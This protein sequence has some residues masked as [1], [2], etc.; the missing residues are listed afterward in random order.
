MTE[1]RR[2]KISSRQI[3]GI[4]LWQP[5]LD[6]DPRVGEGVY[7]PHTGWAV[8][9]GPQP[10]SDNARL[11]SLHESY[12]GTLNDSTSY[13]AMLH[14]ASRFFKADPSNENMSAFFNA[15]SKESTETHELYATYASLYVVS[16]GQPITSLLLPYNDYQEFFQ[17]AIN[18]SSTL[19]NSLMR[20][21]FIQSACRCCMQTTCLENLVKKSPA[22]WRFADIEPTDLPDKRLKT[23]RNST[24]GNDIGTVLRQWAMTQDDRVQWLVNIEEGD[25]RAYERVVAADFDDVLDQVGFFFYDVVARRLERAGARV[26]SFNGHQEAVR[27]FLR[28]M[29]TYLPNDRS[30]AP[31]RAASQGNATE[32]ALIEQFAEERL[33]ISTQ[34]YDARLYDIDYVDDATLRS[35]LTGPVCHGSLVVRPVG[36]LLQLYRFP[37]EDRTALAGGFEVDA[38]LVTLRRRVF[39][40]GI[41]KPLIEHFIVQSPES[42]SRLN[43]LTAHGV[44]FVGS[45][46]LRSAADRSWQETWLGPL[47]QFV[48]LS[49]LVD[50]NPF[51]QLRA[52]GRQRE[53]DVLYGRIDIRNAEAT[54]I[55]Y[56]LYPLSGDDLVYIIPCSGI[57]ANAITHTITSLQDK[58]RFRADNSVFEDIRHRLEYTLSHLLREE[59]WFDFKLP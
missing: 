41:G 18:I 1:E 44:F 57:V 9:L 39:R 16:K 19:P 52:W 22:T 48:N 14:V 32:A 10:H 21:L 49:V 12:H 27:D 29:K 33:V 51:Y 59:P 50:S 25:T 58:S 8:R 11:V 28:A 55:V 7:G 42:L 23:L 56:G 46:S 47:A 37:N 54:H 35:L 30:L 36:R 40:H 31:L 5:L 4:Q 15:T 24:I 45:L 53:Y 20:F 3:A 17:T 13:G 34:P 43:A 6:G 38:Q 2:R 26:L